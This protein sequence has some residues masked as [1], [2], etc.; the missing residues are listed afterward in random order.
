MTMV[1]ADNQDLFLEK[2]KK[3]PDGLYYLYKDQWH[4]ATGRQEIFHIKGQ[5]DVTRTIYETRHGVLLNGILND[6]PHPDLLVPMP[7][8]QSLGVALSWSAYE[9]D[10][11][12]DTSFKM[13]LAKSADEVIQICKGEHFYYSPELCN[14]R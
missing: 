14:G 13:M 3:E 6:E 2:L 11:T 4:K 10:R 9:P 7:V 5:K 12:M 8:N 1:M